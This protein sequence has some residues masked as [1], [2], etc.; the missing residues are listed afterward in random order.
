VVVL[1]IIAIICRKQFAA[2]ALV[3]GLTTALVLLVSAPLALL[4]VLLALRGALARQRLTGIA[5]VAIQ[6]FPKL[7]DESFELGQLLTLLGQL[8]T[9]L[10]QLPLKLCVACRQVLK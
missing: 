4:P 8:L 2:A 1:N 10:G 5:R 6:L 3:P 9:L 7:Y